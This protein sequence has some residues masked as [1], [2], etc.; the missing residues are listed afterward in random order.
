MQTKQHKN[1]FCA[2]LFTGKVDIKALEKI[3]Y[4]IHV[5]GDKIDVVEYLQ[6]LW[7]VCFFYNFN[8]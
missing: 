7:K 1:S 4:D 3:Y 5:D 6:S 2:C 8:L